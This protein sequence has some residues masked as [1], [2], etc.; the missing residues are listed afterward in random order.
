M[1]YSTKSLTELADK[2]PEVTDKKAFLFSTSGGGEMN[3]KR[4]NYPILR[5]KLQSKGYLILDEFHCKGFLGVKG[6]GLNRGRPNAEDLKH[7][8]EFAENLK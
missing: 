2:L 4:E 3:L 6:L 5:K 8:E 7:A 1:E